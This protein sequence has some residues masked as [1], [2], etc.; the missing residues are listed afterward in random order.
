MNTTD[1]LESAESRTADRMADLA[2]L[3]PEWTELKNKLAAVC[4][5]EH[6]GLGDLERMDENFRELVWSVQAEIRGEEF[7][8]RV[9]WFR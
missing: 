7:Q 2:K 3:M 9:E 1:L 8:G 5:K 4:N 6:A